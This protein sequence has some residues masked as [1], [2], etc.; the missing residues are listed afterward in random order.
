[1]TDR[2]PALRSRT[3]STPTLVAAWPLAL[4][5]AGCSGGGGGGSTP[6]PAGYAGSWNLTIVPDATSACAGR[7]Q[8][9]QSYRIEVTQSGLEVVAADQSGLQ[10][11]GPVTATGLLLSGR[12]PISGGF[13]TVTDLALVLGS[14][15]TLTGDG[16]WDQA[17]GASQCTGTDAFR[18]T[19]IPP[20]QDLAG[21]WDLNE[22]V[23]DSSCTLTTP[24]FRDTWTLTQVGDR[25]TVNRQ[26]SGSLATG[27]VE[28][29]GRLVLD[30]DFVDPSVGRILETFYI[31]FLTDRAPPGLTAISEWSYP[32]CS[33]RSEH[34]GLRTSR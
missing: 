3:R 27:R 10:F 33:G 5:L 26:G 1:M 18:A 25:V 9:L 32:G 22:D 13:A 7:T 14:D 20:L 11:E 31:E 30:F 34:T 19:R 24:R 21:T 8:A 16:D 17:I 2:P 12:Y 28:A 23:L 29:S 6:D 15:G 4:A